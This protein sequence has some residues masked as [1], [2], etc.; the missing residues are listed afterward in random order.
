MLPDLDALEASLLNTSGNVKLDARFRTLF[1]LKGLA[2]LSE[3]RME[4]V[5]D[6]ISKGFGDDSALLKHEMA[7]VLGQLK[8]TRALPCLTKILSDE[9]EH[10]M[11]RHEAAEA[12]GAISSPEALPVLNEYLHDPDV[13]VRE[14]CHLA[15][16]K[17]E[18]DNSETGKKEQEIKEQRDKAHGDAIDAAARAAAPIDPAPAIVR[19]P[20]A[21]DEQNVYTLENVPLFRDTLMNTSLSLFDRYRAMFA[22]RNTVQQGGKDAETPAVLALAD[23]L[24]D[25][26]A[27][28]RHEICFVFGE[29][30]HPASVPAMTRVL[31]DDQEHEMVRHEAAEALGGVLE[32]ADDDAAQTQAIE[33]LK[34]WAEDQQAPRVVRESC[35]VALDEMAYNNDPTQFQPMDSVAA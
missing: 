16:N 6:I 28:F 2:S 4:R 35:V 1:T 17:I 8:D 24:R 25:E 22:L 7:Y 31:N 12:M 23:G 13:S 10:A 21:Q 9:D 20:N 29:L 19:V 32:E 5:I 14:T 34:R 15:I 30:C 26:S 18:L 27:L 3:D 33:T 11:V